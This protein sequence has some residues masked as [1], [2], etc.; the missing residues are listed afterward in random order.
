[1]GFDT[2]EPYL[3]YP[4]KGVIV[5][6]RTSNAG[7]SDFQALAVSSEELLY[8]RIARLAVSQWNTNQQIS[9]VVGATF[10]TELARV[11]QIVG[12]MPLLVP[13][14][15]VQGGD[16]QATVAAGQDNL[17]GGYGMMISSSRAILYASNGLDF[18]S[19]AAVVAQKTRDT[20]RLAGYPM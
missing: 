2:I 13:G 11:R 8:E 17:E 18:A 10:P 4:N 7:G 9:L 14:I 12:N 6:C 5:L 20:I 19:A 15:G 16:I 3:A 1:M